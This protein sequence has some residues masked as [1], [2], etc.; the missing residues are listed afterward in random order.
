MQ[1]RALGNTGVRVSAIGFGCWGIGGGWGAPDDETDIAEVQ[2]RLS[3]L[4]P[5][6]DGDTPDCATL[7]LRFSLSHPAV[8]TVIVGM[9][10]A[11]HVTSNCRAADVPPLTGATLAELLKHPFVHGWFYPWDKRTQAQGRAG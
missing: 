7:A 4:R 10:D 8:S 2:R 5:F 11:R 6:L 3:A 9:R 1:Y